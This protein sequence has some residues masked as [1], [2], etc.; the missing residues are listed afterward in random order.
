MRCTDNTLSV[1]QHN[2]SEQSFSHVPVLMSTSCLPETQR[3]MIDG[4]YSLQQSE[5]LVPLI[6]HLHLC[7]F[8]QLLQYSTVSSM[9]WLISCILSS[10]S[11]MPWQ[12]QQ[13]L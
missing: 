6:E 1:A 7:H 4:F 5:S 10:L 9:S 3:E 12:V 13:N 2:M 8:L 11:V